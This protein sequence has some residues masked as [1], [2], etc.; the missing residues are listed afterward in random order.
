MMDLDVRGFA[1]IGSR[2]FKIGRSLIAEMKTFQPWRELKKIKIPVLFVHGDADEAVCIEDSIKYSKVAKNAALAVITGGGHG[3]Y[4]S[5]AVL[6]ET[7]RT[8]ADFMI[9]NLK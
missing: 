6:G 8:I 5:S 2:G 7:V 3:L 9:K 1:K 4:N